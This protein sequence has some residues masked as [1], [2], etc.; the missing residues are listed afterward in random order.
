MLLTLILIIGVPFLLALPAYLLP[1]RWGGIISLLAPAS[2]LAFGVP[3]WPRV[4]EGEVVLLLIPWFESMG[5]NANLRVDRL[6]VFFVLLIGGIGLGIVQYSRGYFKKEGSSPL[7]WGSLLAFMGAMLGIALADSLI[8]LFVFWELTTITSALLIGMHYKDAKARRGAIQAFLVTGAGSLAMLAGIVLLGLRA[9]S[10]S[11]FELA[12]QAD[13][14]VADPW[15]R[16]ALVLILLGAFTKSAQFPFHFWLPGAMEAPAPV[17]AFLHSAAMVK[18]G[19]LLIGRMVPLFVG[20]DLWQPILVSVGLTTY[21]VTGFLALKARDLKLLLAYSTAAFL[22][23]IV[24]FYGYADGPRPRGELLHI[25][26]HAL[27]KSSLFLLVGWLE[28]VSGTRDLTLLEEHRWCIRFPLAGL[29]FAIGAPA[30]AGFPLLLGFVSKEEFYKA[31]MGGAY[32]GLSLALIAAIVGSILTVAYALKVFVSTFW[33]PTDPPEVDKSIKTYKPSVWLLI[34]PAVFLIPQLVGG[35]VPARLL[36]ILEPE[37]KWT[38]GPAFFHQ[39]DAKLWISLLTYG[40]GLGLYLSWRRVETLP[41]IPG[42]QYIAD[43]LSTWTLSGATWLS[44]AMQHGGHPRHLSLILLATVAALFAGMFSTGFEVSN[45]A[46]PLGPDPGKGLIPTLLIAAGAV[47][48]LVL[49]GRL[50]KIL[51]M[52]LV[53]FAVVGV[54]VLFRAPDLALTQILTESIMLILLLL[55]VRKFPKLV[56]DPRPIRQK[57][58]HGIVAMVVGLSMA[59]LTW[60]A[61]VVTPKDPAGAEHLRL[62]YP[63]AKGHNVVNVILVDFRG[64]DTLGEILVL[65]VASLGIVALFLAGRERLRSAVPEVGRDS[66]PNALQTPSDSETK[67]AI[68]VPGAQGS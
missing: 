25:A 14:I 19:I 40:L 13:S 33:G 6:G 22:G 27:Y 35:I 67:E 7:F 62:A 47:L 59:T 68:E 1:G 51:A 60:S 52:S 12:E 48:T 57:W 55:I 15:H 28:K 56:S 21:I 39:V 20:S 63:E 31:I 37:Q 10:F 3:L 8:L 45:L 5:I 30:M 26:N 49:R 43:K 4:A 65:A 61:S 53:G 18:A 34:V 29:L 46:G 17:S 50:P 64:V 24:A 2:V 36:G 32:S 42:P 41:K 9:G 58:A 66:P 23:V 54:F 44:K 16:P 11:L 38:E